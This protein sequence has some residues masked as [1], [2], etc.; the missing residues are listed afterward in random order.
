MRIWIEVETFTA[1]AAAVS[2]VTLLADPDENMNNH[3]GR[4]KLDR[5]TN[6][7]FGYH[8]KNNELDRDLYCRYSSGSPSFSKKKFEQTFRMP[9]DHYWKARVGFLGHSKFW[10]YRFDATGKYGASTVLKVFTA[11][12]MIYDDQTAFTLIN[13]VRQSE[14]QNMKCIKTLCKHII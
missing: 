3:R 9:G 1:I 8:L 13:Q 5:A 7:N 2:C 12:Q 10:Q 11:F 6:R 4:S 14:P